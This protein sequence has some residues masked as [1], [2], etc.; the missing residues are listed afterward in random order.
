[1]KNIED[2]VRLLDLFWERDELSIREAA[3]RLNMSK[4]AVHRL[5][6]TLERVGFLTQD[7]NTRM[8]HLGMRL[9]QYGGL[10]YRQSLFVG[11]ALP[12]LRRLMRLT[13]ETVH[14]AALEVGRV[15][16]LVRIESPDMPDTMPSGPGWRNP[17]HSTAAG[18]ALLA[19]QDTSY[20][21]T[22]LNRSLE[23]FTPNTY[24]DHDL[25][26]RHLRDVR[27]CGI[28]FDLEERAIG[29]RCIG[30][31]L[32]NRD[33]EAIASIS[34]AG[35]ISRLTSSRVRQLAPVVRECAEI[36]REILPNEDRLTCVSRVAGQIG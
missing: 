31:P 22:L 12:I 21:E 10:A 33:G 17:A 23:R 5:A 4:S 26:L 11:E 2:A 9:L 7:P 15:V 14:L 8:Y 27:S 1:M 32:L 13:G 16:Y 30:A 35:S 3:R 18:K 36:L 20:T 24:T 29:F 34:I 6:S 19:F 28:A 25:L